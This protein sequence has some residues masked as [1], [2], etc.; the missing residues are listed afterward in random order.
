MEKGKGERQE[1]ERKTDTDSKADKQTDKWRLKAE[2]RTN[3][4]EK[5]RNGE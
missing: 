2:K 3:E 1:R 4:I 5:N